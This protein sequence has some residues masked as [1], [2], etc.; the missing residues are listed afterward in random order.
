MRKAHSQQKGVKRLVIG[1][2]MGLIFGWSTKEKDY[3]YDKKPGDKPRVWYEIYNVECVKVRCVY[4]FRA[5]VAIFWKKEL[6]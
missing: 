3:W 4:M 2:C 1:K 6:F 5:Y